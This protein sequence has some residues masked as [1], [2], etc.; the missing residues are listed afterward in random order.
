MRRCEI[1]D[2]E[3]LKLLC[4]EEDEIIEKL[5]SC[6]NRVDP[7]D[8]VSHETQN[9]EEEN[10]QPDSETDDE[11]D[12]REYKKNDQVR[13]HQFDYDKTTA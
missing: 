7:K 5:D 9:V 10:E 3:G 4:P 8:E 12:D 6:Q 13:K 11:T 1:K 2:P